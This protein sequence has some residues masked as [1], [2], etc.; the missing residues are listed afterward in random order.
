[1]IP[2]S[3]LRRELRPFL[4]AL[5][6]GSGTDPEDLEQSVWLGALE[7][8]AAGR[9][10][11]AP[12]A[13]LRGLAVREALAAR[14]GAVEIPVPKVTQRHLDPA[15]QLA[16]AELRRAVRRALAALPGRCPELLAALAESPELTYRQLA[17]RLGVPR[18]SLGP[19]RSRCLGCLRALLAARREEWRPGEG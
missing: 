15:L 8:A 10:P 5:A 4:A 13:W 7:R 16:R 3:E 9:L 11:A 14:A 6:R 18:G 1:M 12:A 19:T 2:V 17:A